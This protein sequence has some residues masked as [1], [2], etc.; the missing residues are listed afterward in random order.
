MVKERLAMLGIGGL[1]N[2]AYKE[3]IQGK[4]FTER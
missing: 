2:A 4:P 1:Q 3:Y